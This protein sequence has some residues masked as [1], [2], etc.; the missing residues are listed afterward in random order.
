MG[1]RSGI[2]AV[3]PRCPIP[4]F[5]PHGGRWASQLTF[6]RRQRSQFRRP[7]RSLPSLPAA[8]ATLHRQSPPTMHC[9]SGDDAAYTALLTQLLSDSPN[10][11]DARVSPHDPPDLP[12]LPRS[13]ADGPLGRLS[14]LQ[15]ALLPQG[16]REDKLARTTRVRAFIVQEMVHWKNGALC[17]SHPN[18]YSE[19]VGCIFFHP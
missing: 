3:T 6:S 9:I 11:R 1:R 10:T 14:L 13:S 15:R 7:L 19:N 12:L 5:Q 4:A 17:T 2:A 16:R 18:K 8:P